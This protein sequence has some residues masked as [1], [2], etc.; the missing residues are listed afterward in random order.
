MSPPPNLALAASRT[1]LK[2]TELLDQ[3]EV[4]PSL[5]AAQLP[6]QRR[7][8][9]VNVSSHVETRRAVLAFYHAHGGSQQLCWLTIPVT[10]PGPQNHREQDLQVAQRQAAAQQEQADKHMRIWPTDTLNKGLRVTGNPTER[11]TA[12]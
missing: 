12:C 3:P 8:L 4:L 5:P 11:E 1:W 9:P 6:A 2:I 10:Q 7:R